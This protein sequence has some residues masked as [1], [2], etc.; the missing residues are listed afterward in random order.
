VLVI[1]NLV[2]IACLG[3]AAV[4]TL[5]FSSLTGIKAEPPLMLVLGLVSIAC[6]LTYRLTRHERNLYLPSK[7]GHVFGIPIWMLGGFWVILGTV[8]MV[9][10]GPPN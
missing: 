9:R 10:G 2:A 6:D 4:A 3:I 1:F 7:G 8:R 5:L